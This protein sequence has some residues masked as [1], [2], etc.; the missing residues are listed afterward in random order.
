MNIAIIIKIIKQITI[1]IKIT[2]IAFIM[3]NQ[4][5]GII[6][7]GIIEKYIKLTKWYH[8]SL[9]YQQLQCI[10]TSNNN[11]INNDGKRKYKQ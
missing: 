3:I 1:I 11:K 6:I 8:L 5:V 2:I 4:D 9:Q 10:K 7:G